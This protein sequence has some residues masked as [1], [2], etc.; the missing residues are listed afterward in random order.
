MNATHLDSGIIF[1]YYCLVFLQILKPSTWLVSD[2]IVPFDD[3]TVFALIF[4]HDREVSFKSQVRSTFTRI[5]I[6]SHFTRSAN[7]NRTET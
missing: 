3:V 4:D 1:D 7:K 6:I 2:L 5:R